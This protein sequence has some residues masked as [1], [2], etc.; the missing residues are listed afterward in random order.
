MKLEPLRPRKSSRSRRV[1]AALTQLPPP[2]LSLLTI[3][4]FCATTTRGQSTVSVYLPGYNEADWEALRGSIVRSDQAATTYTVFCADQAPTCQIAGDLPF[5][6]AAGQKTLSYGGAAAGEITA[7]LHCALAEKTAA[8]CTG[9]TSFASGYHQGTI[10]GPTQTVWTK[11]FSGSQ[12]TWGVLTL[13]TPGPATTNTNMDGIVF[14]PP[15]GDAAGAAQ[16][17]ISASSKR[18]QPESLVAALSAAGVVLL[19]TALRL[20]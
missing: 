13:T 6:F 12:V 15:T 11:T 19:T 8:T 7:D 5:I 3:A 4:G 1:A 9:S 17:S 2:L 18:S 10:S 14:T 20:V 16:T